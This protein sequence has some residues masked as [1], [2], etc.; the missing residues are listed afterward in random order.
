MDMIDHSLDTSDDKDVE[1][2][3]NDL[4]TAQPLTIVEEDPLSPDG[5]GSLPQGLLDNSEEEISYQLRSADGVTFK[6]ISVAGEE[7][8]E[9]PQIITTNGSTYNGSEGQTVQATALVNS[10]NGQLFVIGTPQEVFSPQNQRNIVPRSHQN[11]NIQIESV[12]GS[13]SSSQCR[14]RDDRRRATH[15]EVERRRRDKINHWI[16]KL[17]KI[18]PECSQDS[19][20]GSFETQS[21]GGILAKACD[22]IMELRTCN[23]RLMECSKENE[24]LAAELES[25]SRQLEE[26]RHENDQL[27][28]QLADHAH[29]LDSLT[30]IT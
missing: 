15:N 19:G 7:I 5:S 30:T 13:S 11:M 27:R 23:Q 24:Q 22:Y 1:S 26:M 9:V 2:E 10:V 12:K 17:G 4:V 8:E 16:M 14:P 29:H 25:V 18:I 20:K 3:M 21:K 6:V 28:A